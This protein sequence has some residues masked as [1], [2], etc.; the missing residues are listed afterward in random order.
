MGNIIALILNTLVI[1]TVAAGYNPPDAINSR[2]L[3]YNPQAFAIISIR[4]N[5]I[6][7]LGANIA[8]L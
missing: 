2:E 3:E 5:C 1:I 4:F 7:F 8:F 6:A